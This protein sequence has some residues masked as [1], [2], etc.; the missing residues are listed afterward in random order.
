MPSVPSSVLAIEQIERWAFQHGLHYEG[1]LVN[2]AVFS[3]DRRYRYL[4]WRGSSPFESFAAFAMLNPSTANARIGDPTVAR[5]NAFAAAL[6]QPLLIWNLFALVATHP[7]ALGAA[8]D[9]IGPHND[10]V[11]DLVL[12][13]A[14]LTVAAW[15]TGGNLHGRAQQ[16][17]RRCATV[18]APLHTLKLTKGGE[19]GHPLYLSSQLRPQPWHYPY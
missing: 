17:L 2:G 16:V 5:C 19:P 14:S 11:I 13:L 12:P 8:D 6:G 18:D 3:A 4:L 9:P 1:G 15:G 7:A 10:A